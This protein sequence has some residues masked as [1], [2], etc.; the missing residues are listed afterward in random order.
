MMAEQKGRGGKKPKYQIADIGGPDLTPQDLSTERVLNFLIKGE[1]PA[2]QGAGA[3]VEGLDQ[4]GLSREQTASERGEET[5]DAS[6]PPP[7][8]KAKRVSITSSSARARAAPPPRT[9]NST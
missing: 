1:A 3:A 7:G 2:D 8:P 9:S 5:A 6:L 4:A